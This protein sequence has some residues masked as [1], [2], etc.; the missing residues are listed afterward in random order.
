MGDPGDRGKG[1]EKGKPVHIP[2][3]ILLFGLNVAHFT[4]HYTLCAFPIVHYYTL[5]IGYSRSKR[6]TWRL[7][8]EGS[9]DVAFLP[10]III[11]R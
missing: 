11:Y 2:P 10:N 8:S 7:W 4:I 6:R 3:L 5:F 9:Y 1:G